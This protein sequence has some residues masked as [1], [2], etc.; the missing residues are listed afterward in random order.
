MSPGKIHGP[1]PIDKIS[2]ELLC[3]IFALE[4]GS[5]HLEPYGFQSLCSDFDAQIEAD[6]SGV[7]AQV[8]QPM[9]DARRR[10]GIKRAPHKRRP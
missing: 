7:W 1:I 10:F 3:Q 8:I 5:Q 9:N 4:G 2:D 6:L